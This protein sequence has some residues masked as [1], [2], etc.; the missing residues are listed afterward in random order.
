MITGMFESPSQA[1][2][3]NS[4]ED[5]RMSLPR[6]AFESSLFQEGRA[7]QYGSSF[8]MQD[9]AQVG[10]RK[11]L[12]NL[13]SQ[14][15]APQLAVY[16]S[17]AVS[18]P[19]PVS[20]AFA[21][22]EFPVAG[23]ATVTVTE[24]YA[25]VD[26]SGGGAGAW[27][28]ASASASTS[29]LPFDPAAQFGVPTVAAAQAQTS[30][31]VAVADYVFSLPH[32]V[33]SVR[34]LELKSVEL[35]FFHFNVSAY[36]QNNRVVFLQKQ[37]VAGS[38]TRTVNALSLSIP[39]GNYL[40]PKSL[41]RALNCALLSGGGGAGGPLFGFSFQ[42]TPASFADNELCE[43][44]KV[45]LF[46]ANASFSAAGA[47]FGEYEVRFPGN[48][49][50]SLGWTLGFRRP[51]Y[52]FAPQ[53]GGALWSQVAESP[54]KLTPRYYYVAVDEYCARKAGGS[55]LAPYASK[56]LL[57]QNIL[58]RAANQNAHRMAYSVYLAA[59]APSASSAADAPG[60]LPTDFAVPCSPALGTLTSDKRLY[61]AK[62][63][64]IQRLRVQILDE[65]GV[66]L[67]VQGID[68]SLC[69]ELEVLE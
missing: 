47:G 7:K 65:Y 4:R 30:F 45:Q 1:D 49:G 61:G 41:C 13:D 60:A 66:A 21:S 18:G 64:D 40:T 22:P 34:S 55:F 2:H 11:V 24:N 25:H 52:A 63:V 20:A 9:V 15:G 16:S 23:A 58:A 46:Y 28:P 68:F 44:Y 56:H 54:P 29:D 51:S 36:L 8:V 19:A 37:A 62:G 31:K 69:L 48:I 67:D 50:S 12:L 27:G 33:S 10:T 39:D 32:K 43:L 42:P 3:N 26:A 35:P 53:A 59:N 17:Q 14:F 6:S 38:A 5:G 57:S